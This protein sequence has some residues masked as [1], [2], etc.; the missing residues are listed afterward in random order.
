MVRH[1]A[2]SGRFY[3]SEGHLLTKE[4]KRHSKNSSTLTPK[5][6]QAI[7]IISPH[8]GLTYCGEVAGAIYSQIEIPETII[9][10]GPNH[11]GTGEQVS[12]M[13]E[14]VWKMPQ[15]KIEIDHELADEIC[16]I[17]MVAKKDNTAH[18]K[19]HSIETQLPFLQFYRDNFKI[20]PICIMRLGLDKCEELSNA[21]V[22]AVKKTKSRVLIIASSDMTHYESHESASKKDKYAIDQILK[23]DA[24]GLY[25]TVRDKNISMCGVNPAVIMLMSANKIGT[26]EA[27]LV[28][29]MTSGEVSGDMDHVV[30]YA[31]IIVK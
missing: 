20:V 26:K 21:I 8:A 14:G 1:P 12:I 19:E 6:T 9:L 30:G 24:K 3:P 27:V 18:Q 31:G 11:T 7:G 2:V 10:I 25:N 29:Y 15:G 22:K 28:K 16:Q 23:L 13:P 5:K 4:I 17:S